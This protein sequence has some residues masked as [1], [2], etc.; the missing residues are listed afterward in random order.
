M[1]LISLLVNIFVLVGVA[2]DG[3]VFDEEFHALVETT[4]TAPVAGEDRLPGGD[5]GRIG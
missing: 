3:V 5:V 4:G 2:L 1:S